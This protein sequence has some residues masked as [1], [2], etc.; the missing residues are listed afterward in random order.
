MKQTV[1]ARIYIVQIQNRRLQ[2][3]YKQL[4]CVP[5]KHFTPHWLGSESC[6]R[7]SQQHDL[8][9]GFLFASGHCFLGKNRSYDTTNT[10]SIILLSLP[11]VNSSSS[12]L[13]QLY[14]QLLLQFFKYLFLCSSLQFLIPV[15][16]RSRVL[17][18]R[19]IYLVR[20]VFKLSLSQEI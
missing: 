12:Y 14:F 16:L 2:K 8:R 1:S 10:F 19:G 17:V 11:I 3:C 6:F 20:V 15:M 7:M 5:K 13:L 4:N 9:C 18:S